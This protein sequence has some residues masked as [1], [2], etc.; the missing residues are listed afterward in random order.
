M[1]EKRYCP[2]AAVS[3]SPPFHALFETV[4]ALLGLPPVGSYRAMA[5]AI[6]AF[7]LVRA[8]KTTKMTRNELLFFTFF[9]IASPFMLIWSVGGLETPLLAAWVTLFAAHFRQFRLSGTA[10]DG[11]LV[12]VG[13]LAGLAFLTRHDSVVVI[14]P[15]Y[16][17]IVAQN[18][19]RP[20]H[21]V[22]M[23]L[24]GLSAV[25]WLGF[26]GL[27]YGDILPTS[28]YLKLF[29]A[30]RDASWH[31]AAAVNFFVVSGGVVITPIA[32]FA[33]SHAGVRVLNIA[34]F[35][36]VLGGVAYAFKTSGAHMFFAYRAFVPYLPAMAMLLFPAVKIAP[37]A[38][39]ALALLA[40]VAA[41][42][43]MCLVGLTPAYIRA[44]PG[45]GVLPIEYTERTHW[46]YAYMQ[47][48]LRQDAAEIRAHWQT[49]EAQ[50]EP[51]IF[52]YTGGMG[53]WLPEF[54]V[55]EALVDFRKDCP[56]AL[57]QKLGAAHYMQDLG[58]VHVNSELQTTFRNAHQNG[59]I[60]PLA[61]TPVTIDGP[62]D[63]QYWF[64]PQVSGFRFPSR[65]NDLCNL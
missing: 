13:V 64:T 36:A 57:A 42:S 48:A 37:K 34:L 65:I 28:A 38:T 60:G 11:A 55:F 9:S 62:T 54:H 2:F 53:Y 43:S 40:N 7:F 52:L 21:W 30:D 5:P 16:L 58:S 44:L 18:Y 56:H 4:L 39:I 31:V 35:F 51:S 10:S 27:Y 50:T 20:A 17:G 46:D 15:L 12:A 3:P 1:R 33:A 63:L 61:T 19:K 45:F 23:G 49:S 8:I 6:L 59:V 29:E 24:G 14:A 26:A 47:A 22:G 32:L 25:T 41:L